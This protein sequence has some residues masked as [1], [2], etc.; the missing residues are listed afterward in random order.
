MRKLCNYILISEQQKPK[1]EKMKQKQ[2]RTFNNTTLSSVIVVHKQP[3]SDMR[4]KATI[5]KH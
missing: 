2:T 1:Q 4:W 3:L 5:V